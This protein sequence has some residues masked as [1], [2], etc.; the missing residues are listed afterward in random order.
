MSRSPAYDRHADWYAEYLTGAA[1]QHT[2]RTAAALRDVLGTGQGRCLDVGCGTGVHA[3]ALHQLGWAVVGVD[4]S[5]GQLR[6]ARERLPVA[7]A[8]AARL[9]FADASMAA[10]VATLLHTDVADWATIVAEVAR[11]LQPGGRLAYVGVHPCFVGPSAA[12][13]GHTVRLYPGYF[14]RDLTFEGPGI[15]SGIRPR[16]GVRHRTITDLLNPLARCG[17]ALDRVTETGPDAFPDLLAFVATKL[18]SRPAL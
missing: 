14:N 8:D 10:V 7:V 9:P 18:D 1:R 5:L 12:R 3:A 11:V 6:H 2:Q 16:V 13:E 4:V 15:G 17:M